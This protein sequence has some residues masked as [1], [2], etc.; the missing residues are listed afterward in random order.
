MIQEMIVGYFS[1]EINFLALRRLRVYTRLPLTEPFQG[2]IFLRYTASGIQA[3]PLGPENPWSPPLKPASSAT[4]AFRRG[5]G[6][7]FSGAAA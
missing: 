2:T 6:I 3:P 1:A 4:S 5:I 7:G